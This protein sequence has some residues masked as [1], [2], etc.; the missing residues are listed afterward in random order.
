MDEDGQLF[1][2][3]ISLDALK[4]SYSIPVNLRLQLSTKVQIVNLPTKVYLF[5]TN[6][7]HRPMKKKDIFQFPSR[8][9]NVQTEDKVGF[10]ASQENVLTATNHSKPILALHFFAP[11]HVTIGIT[12]NGTNRKFYDGRYKEILNPKKKSSTFHSDLR[13]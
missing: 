5:V 7:I 3:A 11:K 2:A 1:K 8:K 4:C 13:T 10:S 6:S 12:I 9:Q